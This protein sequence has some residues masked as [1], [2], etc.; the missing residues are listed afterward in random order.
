MCPGSVRPLQSILRTRTRSCV[1]H[2]WRQPCRKVGGRPAPARAVAARA[3]ASASRRDAVLAATA[4]LALAAPG[5]ALAFGE[6][7]NKVYTDETVRV[8]QHLVV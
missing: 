2:T 4:A 8:P 6:D 7:I 3:A 1:A 5:A